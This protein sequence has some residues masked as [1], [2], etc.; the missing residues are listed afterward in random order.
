MGI[1]FAMAIMGLYMGVSRRH[2]H[3]YDADLL[4]VALSGIASVVIVATWLALPDARSPDVGLYV[5][6]AGAVIGFLGSLAALMQS[7]RDDDVTDERSET[8]SRREFAA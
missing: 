4:G 1:G 7:H 8:D 6:L 3:W 2:G 5:A